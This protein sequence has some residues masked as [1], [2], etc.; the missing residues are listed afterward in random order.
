M[1][2]KRCY[3]LSSRIGINNVQFFQTPTRQWTW[4]HYQ[5]TEYG[6]SDGL[7]WS[8]ST[9]MK[10]NKA[11]DLVST[12]VNVSKEQ[13][14]EATKPGFVNDFTDAFCISQ[15]LF[16]S[17]REQDHIP[18]NWNLPYAQDSKSELIFTE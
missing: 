14:N 7:I 17:Q 2:M 3:W 12:N 10:T 9:L 16:E 18:F 4:L 5:F 15:C 6:K 11:C 1:P 13:Q 8:C